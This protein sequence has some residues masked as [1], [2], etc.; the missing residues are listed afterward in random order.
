MNTNELI[1][2]GNQARAE[3]LPEQAL[4]YYAQALTQDRFSASAFNNY[5]NVLRE[6]GD[7][8]GAIPFLQR[9]IQLAPGFVTAEFNLAVAYLLQ[10]NYAQGWKQYESRWNYEHLAGTLPNY[11]QPRW[12]GQDL[13]N[14][15]IFVLGEQGHGDTIQFLRFIGI[16]H[17]MGAQIILQ[18]DTNIRS[19]I[20]GSPLV[21]AI[22]NPG[23]T[24]E[25]FDY[26]IPIMSLPGVLGITVENLARPLNYLAANSELIKEWHKR[27]GPKTRLRVGFC[28]SGRRDSWINQHKAMPFEI[29][30]DLIK[31][32]PNYEWINLQIDCTPEQESELSKLGVTVYPG[33]IRHWADTAALVHHL[34]VVLSVDTAIA[35]LS[36]ALGRP[37][38]IML[39]NYAVD[40][41]WLLDRDSSPWYPSA[42][43]FR[44]P[45]MGDW[46]S[47]TSK[48][49]QFLSWFK[50]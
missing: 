29:M 6:I 27:L 41:R 11:S 31:Q 17:N 1:E 32:N 28:W 47:V 48:I 44:Q 40:W 23:V 3:H 20:E 14:K 9:A 49:H 25:E 38:W 46:K 13:K 18:V 16:L 50:V 33:S 21:S 39:N 15:T 36:G 37:T 19:L 2:F 43:L 4:K 7:P 12:S 24:P 42:R 8:S 35:H 10:G 26:W 30:V 34:D 45:S 22:V 5:G